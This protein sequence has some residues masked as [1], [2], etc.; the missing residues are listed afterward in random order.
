ERITLFDDV[1][2]LIV[3]DGS[4]DVGW[5]MYRT[6]GE[7][8]FIDIIVLLP[9]ERHHGYGKQIIADLLVKNPEIKTIKLD[10][11]QRN[12]SAVAFYKKTG[13][14]VAGEEYQ[15]VDGTPVLYD[16]MEWTV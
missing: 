7:S 14:R 12:H 3:S 13:F 11:Q 8:C 15:P 6:E 10:V 2:S 5:L 9:E 4:K 16:K 1:Q